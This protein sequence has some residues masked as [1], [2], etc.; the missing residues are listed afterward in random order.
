[1]LPPPE[2]TAT[3]R[4]AEPEKSDR[5]RTVWPGSRRKPGYAAASP[6]TISSTTSRGRLISF[7]IGVALGSGCSRLLGTIECWCSLTFASVAVVQP[8]WPLFLELPKPLVNDVMLC[9]TRGSHVP[10]L[11]VCCGACIRRPSLLC[12]LVAGPGGHA[13][14]GNA[15]VTPDM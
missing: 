6:S 4:W 9:L 2:I 10:L 8:S 11:S 3:G 7:F 1:P 13:V 5:I 12:L 14:G 15:D